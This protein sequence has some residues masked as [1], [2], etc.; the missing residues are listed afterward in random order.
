MY[1]RASTRRGAR[2]H[3]TPT[4]ARGSTSPMASETVSLRTGMQLSVAAGSMVR[5]FV[6]RD[7]TPAVRSTEEWL[8]RVLSLMATWP[9][10]CLPS[11]SWP[12]P[13]FGA[14]VGVLGALVLRSMIA[15]GEV[16]PGPFPSSPKTSPD[17]ALSIVAL[18]ANLIA[19]AEV[20]SRLIQ[21]VAVLRAFP[22][23]AAFCVGYASTKASGA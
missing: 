14:L 6:E 5:Y 10:L 7:G 22:L 17:V 16:T 8:R 2:R 23:A 21:R 15:R 1:G 3:F 20:C 18:A 19:W 12:S 4:I 11:S 9:V 13:S